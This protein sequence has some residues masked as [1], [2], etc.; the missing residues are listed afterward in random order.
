MKEELSIV[1]SQLHRKRMRERR[2]AMR[3]RGVKLKEKGNTE[4]K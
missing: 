4:Q 2:K 3:L 1:L